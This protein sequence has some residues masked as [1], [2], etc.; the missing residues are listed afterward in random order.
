MF[1]FLNQG[2][3]ELSAPCNIML[4]FFHLEYTGIKQALQV[5][6]FNV[7]FMS[8][9]VT[10]LVWLLFKQLLF[11]EETSSSFMLSFKFC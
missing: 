2:L 3:G 7:H 10:L 9:P 11:L 4:Q 5:N 1:L 6:D 8:T